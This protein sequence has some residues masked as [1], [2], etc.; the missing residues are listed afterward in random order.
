MT[1]INT[2]KANN[3]TQYSCQRTGT[4]IKLQQGLVDGLLRRLRIKG[5][6]HCVIMKLTFHNKGIQSNIYSRIYLH[7]SG[8]MSYFLVASAIKWWQ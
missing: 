7:G 4:Q 1:K 8:T 5:F 2:I 3:S 6:S